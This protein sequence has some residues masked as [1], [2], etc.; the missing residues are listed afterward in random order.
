MSTASTRSRQSVRTLF[1]RHQPQHAIQATA[2]QRHLRTAVAASALAATAFGG[3]QLVHAPQA[4]AATSDIT[5][6]S[7]A[8]RQQDMQRM[9]NLINQ[10]RASHGI[11]PVKFSQQL[12]GIVQEHSDRQV[13]AERFWH[14]T[15]FMTDPRAGRW[16]HTNEIIALSYQNDVAE[17]VNWWKTSP[18]HNTAMLNPRAEVIGIGLTYADGSLQNTG[19]PWRMLSTINLYGYANGGAPADTSTTVGGYA[20]QTVSPPARVQPQTSGFPIYGGIGAH[21]YQGGGAATFGQP[22]M[23][24]ADASYG[25][26]Y[27]V[28]SKNGLTYK[29]LWHPSTGAH[30]I[31]DFG[32]IGRVWS[33]YGME[34]GLGYPTTD[35]YRYGNEMR[36]N[37][38]NGYTLAWNIHTKDVYFV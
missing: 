15:S 35:E 1:R 27:Q 38:S 11:A 34:R 12:S 16:T 21:Y 26:R 19:Q 5:W 25:G 7:Q 8:Q 23:A 4:E 10:Y 14:S 24:E 6:V 28:F 3:A 22:V 30:W 2:P 31:K 20:P 36:Q 13:A 17:M 18:A 32:G 9:L 29:F 33:Q 37:F